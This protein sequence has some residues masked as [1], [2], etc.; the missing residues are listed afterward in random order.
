[1]KM[2][3]ILLLG[4]TGFIGKVLLNKLEQ[5]HSTKIM[6]HST[7][8]QTTAQK[9]KGNILNKKSFFDE[10]RN[11]ETIINLLGQLTANESDCIKSNILGGLNLLNSCVDKKIRQIILISSINVYGENLKR[12]SKE[13]DPSNPASNYGKIK[14]ITEEMYKNFSETYGINVTVLRLAGIYGPNGNSGFLTQIIKSIKNKNIIP[15]CYNNGEQ[16]RDMLYIDD[17]IDCILN[18]LNS[19][20]R[21]FNIFNISSGNRYSMNELISMIERISKEKISVKYS[22]EIPDEKCIWA[23]NSKAKKLLKFNPKIKIETGLKHM[24]SQFSN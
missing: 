17:A 15:I 10:I 2:N 19:E 4:G 13:T 21:G 6:I 16:Q 20:P 23:D 9:F 11:D 8:L 14:M 22:S 7:N 1:M 18:T 24:I 3:K 5:Y 12:S